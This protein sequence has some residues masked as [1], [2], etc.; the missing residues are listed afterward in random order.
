MCASATWSWLVLR[1]VSMG[2]AWD[3]R[4]CVLH[5][6]SLHFRRPTSVHSH[7]IQL[8][9]ALN[10]LIEGGPAIAIVPSLLFCGGEEREW[11]TT[12]H[13]RNTSVA[14]AVDPFAAIS[15]GRSRR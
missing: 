5:T 7:V 8:P 13:P 3:G 1:R 12:G 15:L 6:K 2:W 9:A 10:P 14:V 4:A 11:G